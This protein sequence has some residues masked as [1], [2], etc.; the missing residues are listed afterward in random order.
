MVRSNKQFYFLDLYFTREAKLENC[1][2]NNIKGFSKKQALS[3][4]QLKYKGPNKLRNKSDKNKNAGNSSISKNY[5]WSYK[6][7]KYIFRTEKESRRT[8][9]AA[10]IELTQ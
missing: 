10:E 2:I 3:W 4:I 9:T 5:H 7:N 8:E 6:V 1:G